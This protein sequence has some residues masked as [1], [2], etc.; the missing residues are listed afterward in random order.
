MMSESQGRERE[1]SVELIT[2]LEN[3]GEKTEK[4]AEC[5]EINSTNSSNPQQVSL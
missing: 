4:V 5:L 1:E 2:Q 3:S